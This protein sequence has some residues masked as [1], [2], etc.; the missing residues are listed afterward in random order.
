MCV[1]QLEICNHDPTEIY[2]GILL[3]ASVGHS[4]RPSA[5]SFLLVDNYNIPYLRDGELLYAYQMIFSCRAI[6]SIS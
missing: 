1:Y 2:A 6:E 4:K 3:Q 5:Y